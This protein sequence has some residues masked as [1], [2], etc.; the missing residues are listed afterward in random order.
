L[1]LGVETCV[2]NPSY[3]DV[4]YIEG[5]A[6]NIKWQLLKHSRIV[7]LRY[8]SI[9]Y[10]MIFDCGSRDHSRLLDVLTATGKYP[11]DPGLQHSIVRHPLNAG[12][13]DVLW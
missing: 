8:N 2:H 6:G 9:G 3:E 10:S 11:L 5:S 13:I 7:E 1:R 12:K 4:G